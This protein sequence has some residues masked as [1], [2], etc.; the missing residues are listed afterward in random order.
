[1]SA[2][3]YHWIE[4]NL[5]AAIGEVGW[6]R[7]IKLKTSPPIFYIEGMEKFATEYPTTGKHP[8]KPVRQPLNA[9]KVIQTV[10]SRGNEVVTEGIEVEDG[11][12]GLNFATKKVKQR[13]WRKSKTNGKYIYSF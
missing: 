12:K 7:E 13:R 4:V 11:P 5:N 9:M 1:M 10:M 3:P 6:T 8:P 2:R